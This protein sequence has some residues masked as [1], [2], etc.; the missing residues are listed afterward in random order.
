MDHT[1][2]FSS[3]S[4]HFTL[5]QILV[6][7][8]RSGYFPNKEDGVFFVGKIARTKNI[9]ENLRESET[10]VRPKKHPVVPLIYTSSFIN[11][12]VTFTVKTAPS[13]VIG[14]D[15]DTRRH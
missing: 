10:K 2:F 11:S 5:T 3:R 14:S 13:G 6:N 9:D 12:L 1:V 4:D 15:R 7:I 8:F